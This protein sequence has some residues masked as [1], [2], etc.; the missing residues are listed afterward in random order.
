VS[1]VFVG[2]LVGIFEDVRFCALRVV[3]CGGIAFIQ[4]ALGAHYWSGPAP[5]QIV[6]DI[7]DCDLTHNV[8]AFALSPG[9]AGR[10]VSLHGFDYGIAGQVID[11]P[12]DVF[13]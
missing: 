13:E 1:T 2:S 10:V 7:W 6:F 8:E 5:Y 9:S 4:G 12:G 11:T 3:V